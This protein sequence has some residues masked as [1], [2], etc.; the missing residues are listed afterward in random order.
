MSVCATLLL[1]HVPTIQTLASFDTGGDATQIL[2]SFDTGDD[3]ANGS[4]TALV[5]KFSKWIIGITILGFLY[6][7]MMISNSDKEPK[8]KER[9][10]HQNTRAFMWAIGIQLG[11]WAIFGLVD[12]LQQNA[13]N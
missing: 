12:T 8:E 11:V 9:E 10:N 7:N 5:L 2:A 1:E 4:I 6:R 13:L 3:G